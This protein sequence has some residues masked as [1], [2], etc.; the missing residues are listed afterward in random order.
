MNLPVYFDGE[1]GF[2]TITSN[3]IGYAILGSNDGEWNRKYLSN[4]GFDTLASSG[5]RLTLLEYI[6]TCHE[7]NSGDVFNWS[8]QNSTKLGNGNGAFEAR[9]STKACTQESGIPT[10]GHICRIF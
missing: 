4:G 1:T 2:L 5:K 10:S 6:S 3:V 9:I 7:Y 8:S